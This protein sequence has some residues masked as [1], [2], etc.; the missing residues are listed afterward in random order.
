M[1][2]TR[3]V[4]DRELNPTEIERM[5]LLLSTFRDGSG[6]RVKNVDGS[7]PD[8]L[9]FERVTAIV[10]GGTTNESKHI[11]DVVAP[12]GPDRLPWG[13]SCK[14]ASEASAKSNCWFMELSNSAKYLT[15]AIENRGVDW[16]TSPEKA[17]PILVGTVKS[18]HEAVRREFDV[19]ASKYL[20]L[21][22]DKAWREF[23]IISFGMDIVHA[24]DPAAIDW[25]VEGKNAEEGDPS[26][27]AGYIDTDSGPLRLWQWYARSGGQ[28]KF[29]PP[30]GWEEWSSVRFELEVAPVHDLQAK[31]EEYW[32]NL[33]GELD[34]ARPE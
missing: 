28:L 6:Q 25:R 19:D 11:F 32:P 13:V 20:L 16:R 14:M 23:Q 21:T 17:G 29:Y 24:V 34:R 18:W 33:W 8:Y 26:S 22:H 5:R 9:G 2:N 4:R 12:G 7:M 15:A 30:K 31:A 27:V 10:L 3:A 1:N